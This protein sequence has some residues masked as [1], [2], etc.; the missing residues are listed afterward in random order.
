MDWFVA[1][2]KWL[3]R[4]LAW[5]L[6]GPLLA[7]TAI[8]QWLPWPATILLVATLA[9]FVGGWRL[10]VF[11]AAALFYGYIRDSQRVE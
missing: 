4:A 1:N 6:S 3:F 8:F 9:H 7:L 2:F 5:I 10:A 11:C